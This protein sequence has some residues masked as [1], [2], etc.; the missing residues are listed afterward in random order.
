MWESLLQT[1]GTFYDQRIE[2]TENQK[3]K[4]MV[5]GYEE[6]NVGETKDVFC[7]VL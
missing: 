5:F 1:S 6:A 3:E 2:W 7:V 4:K